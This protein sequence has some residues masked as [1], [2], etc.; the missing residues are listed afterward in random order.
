LK[1]KTETSEAPL[2][3]PDLCVAALKL[4]REQQEADR[5]RAD[6]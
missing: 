3:L 2:P 5:H 6:P 1:V 4:R